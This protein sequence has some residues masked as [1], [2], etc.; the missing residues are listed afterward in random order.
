MKTLIGGDGAGH[1]GGF[2]DR[3]EVSCELEDTKKGQ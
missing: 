3:A 2:W 1:E